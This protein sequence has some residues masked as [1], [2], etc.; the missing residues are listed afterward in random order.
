MSN[1]GTLETASQ[2]KWKPQMSFGQSQEMIQQLPTYFKAVYKQMN[3]LQQMAKEQLSVSKKHAAVSE[4]ELE[5][6]KLLH[7][8]MDSLLVESR[9][10]NMLLAELIALQRL[11]IPEDTDEMREA[12][13]NDAY[14]K[15]LNGE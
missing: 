6:T 5:W 15:V 1:L 14:N 7:D 9:V 12:I 2:N 11:I 4:N 3:H 13:R 10:T 8:R